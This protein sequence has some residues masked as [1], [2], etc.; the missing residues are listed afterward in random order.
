MH[1]CF[2]LYTVLSMFQNL[3]EPS[4]VNSCSLIHLMSI[5]SLRPFYARN[6][7]KCLGILQCLFLYLLCKKEFIA[8]KL[9][10]SSTLCI[11]FGMLYAIHL[12]WLPCRWFPV[13]RHHV[14]MVFCDYRASLLKI[15]QNLSY[16]SR[17]KYTRVKT[18][19]HVWLETKCKMKF[20][21]ISQ[22]FDEL[23]CQMYRISHFF[24]TF[25]MFCRIK[26]KEKPA[27]YSDC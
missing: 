22:T 23:E 4:I 21:Y 14:A 17:W 8:Y 1:S 27:R 3:C 12:H 18:N 25:S 26:F 20:V 9:P 13:W 15:E 24:S 7:I 11:S 6:S 10:V 2:S 19:W 16:L 5:E